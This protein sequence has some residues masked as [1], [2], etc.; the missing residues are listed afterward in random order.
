MEKLNNGNIATKLSNLGRL[1]H[2]IEDLVKNGLSG[3]P[4]VELESLLRDSADLHKLRLAVTLYFGDY[5]SQYKRWAK[6][7]INDQ[8]KK[9]RC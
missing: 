8:I 7:I 5:E 6:Q 4:A 1:C 9:R 2:E 3:F